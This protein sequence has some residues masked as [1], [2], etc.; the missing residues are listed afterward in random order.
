MEE[1]VDQ[2]TKVLTAHVVPGNY[3]AADL[4]EAV[5]NSDSGAVALTAVSGD[6]IGVQM[7]AGNLVAF[8]ENQNVARITIPDVNQS[9]GVIHVVDSVL[10]PQ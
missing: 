3:T 10:V 9:N 6:T 5:E 2:L 8:D 1:N 7:L 4:M